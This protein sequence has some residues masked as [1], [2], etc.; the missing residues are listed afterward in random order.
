MYT[1]CTYNSYITTHYSVVVSTGHNIIPKVQ[2]Y[3]YT[4]IY[5]SVEYWNTRM[6]SHYIT[7]LELHTVYIYTLL[8]V[9]LYILCIMHYMCCV[10]I[11]HQNPHPLI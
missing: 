5:S 11:H 4:T 1:K 8:L 7:V 9:V 3:P 10:T 2:Y 6:I